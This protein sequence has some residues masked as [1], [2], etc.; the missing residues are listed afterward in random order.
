MSKLILKFNLPEETWESKS[1]LNGSTYRAVLADL[2][3]WLRAK[4]KYGD[5]DESEAT[6]EVYVKV[7]A[8][9]HTLLADY[10][11]DID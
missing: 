7:R 8:Q 6:Q 3:E 11:V 5:E 1:A 9:L 10:S 4:V 2:N